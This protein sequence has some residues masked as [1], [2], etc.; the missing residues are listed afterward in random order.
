[1]KVGDL[2][3]SCDPYENMMGIVVEVEPGRIGED[4]M[5][6]E[7]KVLWCLPHRRMHYHRACTWA[8]TSGLEIISLPS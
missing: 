5:V 8:I 1:M 4:R 3:K 7:I 2:V 6:R